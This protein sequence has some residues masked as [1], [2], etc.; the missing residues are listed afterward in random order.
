MVAWPRQEAVEIVRDGWVRFWIPTSSWGSGSQLSETMERKEGETRS[1]E[2]LKAL[3]EGE[4]NAKRSRNGNA[5][6]V[7]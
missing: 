6:V 7:F 4:G 1:L 2:I 3:E 5:F